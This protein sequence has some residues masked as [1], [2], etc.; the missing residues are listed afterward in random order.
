MNAFSSRTA[1][2]VAAV[3]AATLLGAGAASAQDAPDDCYPIPAEGCDDGVD[4]A[5]DGVDGAD[6][7]VDGADDGVDG[8]DDGVDGVDDGVDG[9]DDGVGGTDDGV[10]GT[11]DVTGTSG[12]S[13]EGITVASDGDAQVL[14]NVLART[15]V[16]LWIL[17]AI[18]VLGLCLG[19]FF[20]ALTRRRRG[21]LAAG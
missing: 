18:G 16:Q 12:G 4:G 1:S 19:V 2:I 9:V 10:G 14:G 8:A 3:A 21:D 13:G 20:L 5:D 15:G 11:D 17:A 7:G 6:D